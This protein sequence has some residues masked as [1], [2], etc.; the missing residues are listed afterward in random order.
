MVMTP[1]P[2]LRRRRHTVQLSV[3]GDG[4]Y[5]PKC[6]CVLSRHPFLTSLRMWLCELYRHSLSH[7]EVRLTLTHLTCA[8]GS[9]SSTATR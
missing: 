9:A 6:L 2:P 8:C 7:A 3:A 5:V 4:L 1:P